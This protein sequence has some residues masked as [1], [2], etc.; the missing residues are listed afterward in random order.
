MV[1]MYGL[2]I[3]FQILMRHLPAGASILTYRKPEGLG[4]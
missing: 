2:L 3:D 1:P 4:A